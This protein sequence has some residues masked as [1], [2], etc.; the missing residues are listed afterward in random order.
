[1][2]LC[3]Y[4]TITRR[5]EEFLPLEG[6][7][8]RMYHCGPTVYSSP[9]IGNFRSFL[10]G[11]LLRRYLEY[12]GYQVLQVMNIT[13]VGHIRDDQDEGEDKIEVAARRERLDPWA[14]AERYT[15]EFLHGV[16][17]LHL[18]KAH[19]YPR[20]TQHIA[21]MIALIEK[22]LAK[23]YAYIAESGTIYFEVNR[24][25]PYGTLSA[26]ILDGLMTGARIEENPEKRD[27]R[28]FALWKI[29]PHH[30]MQW[31]SPWGRGFPGWHIECSAM[32]MHYLGPSFDI[33]T[34]GEDNIFP[35]HECEI[36]QAEAATGRTFVRYWLHARHL[37]VE[38]QKMAKS[39]GN[40]ITLKELEEQGHSGAAVRLML[41]RA[42]YRQ[43]LNFTL[44]GLRE[45]QVVVDRLENL[46]QRL[47]ETA[48]EGEAVDEV[49]NLIES[50]KRAFCAALDDDLNISPA[51]AALHEIVSEANRREPKGADAQAFLDA[52]QEIDS[53]LGL[54]HGGRA[55]LPEEIEKLIAEREQARKRKDYATA[56]RIRG[57]LRARRIEL[58]DTK[59]G[60]RWRR[61][62]GQTA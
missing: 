8:V 43:Q 35:H 30:L 20:A 40:Y 7:R 22:L 17:W 12:R 23:G 25:A 2:S 37:L 52:I 14:I 51:L 26:N 60:V 29:D 44:E 34:G 24:F 33:H 28:D 57:E 45:A 11:D 36:A 4:N 54:L 13:D 39:A 56:D 3:F 58:M 15:Q 55:I 46:V 61:V 5:S 49:R 32:S 53:V 18:K 6:G 59:E 42:H 19:H 62:R 50:E 16:E 27:P 21:Q 38:G 48:A 9:T 41:I 31:D 47:E 10:L 1:M